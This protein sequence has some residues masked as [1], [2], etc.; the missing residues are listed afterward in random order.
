MNAQA[1]LGLSVTSLVFQVLIV[2]VFTKRAIVSGLS[3]HL[4]AVIV[5]PLTVESIQ[6]CR[7]FAVESSAA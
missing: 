3:L 6:E 7:T 4:N 5:S 1:S 2:S